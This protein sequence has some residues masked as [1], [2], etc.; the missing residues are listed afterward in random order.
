MMI[1]LWTGVKILWNIGCICVCLRT[2]VR[3]CGPCL[4][5][6][7][8]R[9]GSTGLTHFTIGATSE[10]TPSTLPTLMTSLGQLT[11][12]C[13]DI[14]RLKP[15]NFDDVTNTELC[16]SLSKPLKESWPRKQS[17]QCTHYHVQT[18]TP[19]GFYLETCGVYGIVPSAP[20]FAELPCM[21]A[22]MYQINRLFC[23]NKFCLNMHPNDGLIIV[24]SILGME[25]PCMCFKHALITWIVQSFLKFRTLGFCDTSVHL[26]YALTFV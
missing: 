6:T 25:I 19:G 23:R 26:K 4:T 21:G 16:H 8:D 18:L 7:N 24:D 17:S 9:S 22:F 15:F 13:E 20:C 3:A 14:W 10:V 1:A 12:C 2:Q 11:P 5:K